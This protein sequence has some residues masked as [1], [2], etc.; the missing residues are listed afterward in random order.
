MTRHSAILFDLDGTL[1]A[2]RRLYFEAFS[3]ALAPHV[4]RRMEEEEMLPYR[5]R[6]ERRFLRELVGD[7]AYGEC[8]EAFYQMYAELHP[9]LF[10][11]VYEGVPEM[12]GALRARS[13]S[14]GLVTGKSRKAWDITAREAPLGP[15]EV[16]VFDDDVPAQKPDPAGLRLALEQLDRGPDE[17]AYV[18]DSIT[19]L[20]AAESAGVLPVA[21]LWPK[22]AEEMEVFA[23]NARER[24]ATLLERPEQLVPTLGLDGNAPGAGGAGATIRGD[25][26]GE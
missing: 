13:V 23:Q 24:G 2:T 4:G 9:T 8:L 5:P 26:G 22:R 17:V 14:M 19:D 3:R 15:F 10:Q 20:E 12:L 7:G 11:G 6:S 1:V 25:N 21:V 18:G 16:T